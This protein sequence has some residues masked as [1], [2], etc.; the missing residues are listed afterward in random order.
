M[1]ASGQLLTCVAMERGKPRSSVPKGAPPK[2]ARGASASI[3][4]TGL[5][6]GTFWLEGGADCS[7]DSSD[8]SNLWQKPE[9]KY[10]VS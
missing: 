5:L 10:Q 9:G 1:W 2:V 4:V 8:K 7:L 6:N 3:M